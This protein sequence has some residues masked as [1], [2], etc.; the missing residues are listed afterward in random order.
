M[1]GVAAAPID[2]EEELPVR[3]ERLECIDE[4]N[5]LRGSEAGAAT[6]V[7]VAI[8]WQSSM[9]INYELQATC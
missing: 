4:V 9:A 8:S 2:L 3:L 6:A 1:L 5:H 7:T